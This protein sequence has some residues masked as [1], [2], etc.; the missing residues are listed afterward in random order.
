MSNPYSKENNKRLLEQAKQHLAQC[1]HNSSH[2]SSSSTAGQQQ[3]LS[4]TT[5]NKNKQNRSINDILM[6]PKNMNRSQ[7]KSKKNTKSNPIK[8]PTR[9]ARGK[10]AATGR[11]AIRDGRRQKHASTSSQPKSINGAK[12][13]FQPASLYLYGEMKK[14]IDSSVSFDSTGKHQLNGRWPPEFSS[15]VTIDPTIDPYN[16]LE[17]DYVEDVKQKYPKRELFACRPVL[18]WAPELRWKELYPDERPCCPYHPGETACVRHN[19][20]SGYY[21]KVYDAQGITALTGRE[22]ICTKLEGEK[23]NNNNN[24]NNNSKAK[25]TFYSYDAGVI[26]QAPLY[27]QS[28]WQQ[29][30][31]RLTEKSGLSFKLLEEARSE[32][33]RGHSASGLVKTIEERYK[34][35]HRR[36]SQKWIG[37]SEPVIREKEELFFD[38]EDPKSQLQVPSLS[39]LLSSV[40]DDIEAKIPYYRHKMTMNGGLF[41]SA[42][43]FIKIGKV[44]LIDNE[45]GFVGLYSVMNEFQQILLWRLVEGTTL[46]EVESALRGLNRRYRIHNFRGPLLLTTD[47]C[48]QERSFFEG[49]NNREKKP[50][51]D[52]FSPNVVHTMDVEDTEVT[53]MAAVATTTT[54]AP[55]A[56]TTKMMKVLAL[57]KEPRCPESKPLAEN[58]AAQLIGKCQEKDW[59]VISLDTEWKLGTKTGPDV[60]QIATPDLDTYIFKKPFPN[61]LITLIESPKIKKVASMIHSDRSKLGEIGVT[62]GGE[63]N[64]QAVAKER[65][66]I[67][68]ATVGLAFIFNKAF[69]KEGVTFDKD[70]VTRISDWSNRKLSSEQKKYAALD[71]L[72]QMLSY[73]KLQAIPFVDPQLPAPK[74]AEVKAGD[75]LLLYTSNMSQIVAEGE[76]KEPWK[77]MVYHTSNTIGVFQVDGETGIRRPSAKV[78]ERGKKDGPTL[79]EL[80]LKST[81]NVFDVRWEMKYTRVASN[82]ATPFAI[83]VPTEE[84]EAPMEDQTEMDDNDEGDSSEAPIPDDMLRECQQATEDDDE[85]DTVDTSTHFSSADK[86][87]LLKSGRIKNDIEHI[88]IRFSKVLSKKHGI[89]A[90]FMARL[91]DVFF[92]PNLEDIAFVK[93]ALKEAGLSDDEI[94][95]LPWV[96]FKRRIRRRVPCPRE[97]E[98]SFNKL[99]N[100]MANVKDAKTNLPFFNGKAWNL[101]KSTLKH[102]RK[103]CLSD[104]PEVAYYVKVDEDS[105]GIPIF[106]CLRGTNA[107]EGFHQK[108]RQILR[109]YNISP[110]YAIALLY[111]FI[112]RWNHDRDIQLLGLSTEYKHFYDGWDL[113]AE[114]EAVGSWDR[115]SSP[116]HPSFECTK[117]FQSTGEDFGIVKEADESVE[118]AA[119]NVANSIVDGTWEEIVVA[120]NSEEQDSSPLANQDL[121]ASASWVANLLGRQR[122][123]KPVHTKAEKDFF[124]EHY[125]RFQGSASKDQETTEADN[126]TSIKWG[127]FARFWNATLEQEDKDDEARSDMTYKNAFSLMEY[128]KIMKREGNAAATALPIFEENKAM[129]RDLRGENRKTSVSQEKTPVTLTQKTPE[130]YQKRSELQLEDPFVSL[131]TAASRAAA[132]STFDTEE[133]ANLPQVRTPTRQSQLQPASAN[134]PQSLPGTLQPVTITRFVGKTPVDPKIYQASL[135]QR[136][137]RKQRTKNSCPRR[138]RTCGRD[139]DDLRWREWHPCDRS[140]PGKYVKCITPEKERKEGFPFTGDR[141]PPRKKSHKLS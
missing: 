37:Y 131:S 1:K 93:G 58:E 56:P 98:K 54:T 18:F 63:L 11:E 34:Q 121:T 23:G 2:K 73:L 91:A 135:P 86:E 3:L 132:P 19:G 111:E 139:A 117:H 16:F 72:A 104:V 66:L 118:E 88:F 8:D 89:F 43:H 24:N 40:I 12:G 51:F 55:A 47:R 26:S 97:L 50:I 141:M 127:E 84:K 15:V 70:K 103:G 130:T 53:T 100:L 69:E 107:L 102:I 20:F 49:E 87:D 80:A 82:E 114:V 133:T 124:R 7:K 106:K 61:S 46:D 48:C 14:K 13:H 128:Y 101:Y 109:G 90:L 32:L 68:R 96:F 29:W 115:L 129:R 64:L 125:I 44:I 35:C 85:N 60:I 110:R 83:E 81:G 4:T 22:Y 137:K 25:Y 108:L 122:G 74:M 9:A 105:Y 136:R 31:F 21:R 138:C 92:V 119:D 62:L 75:R 39:F 33:T 77:S 38:F 123:A 78:L 126:Y 36:Q 116:P 67:E 57:K 45:K 95:A 27:V 42:D 113:E 65:G 41:L 134:H 120:N 6:A 112:H 10:V 79:H 76:F 28:V 17:L 52:S 94:D 5:N 30:G 71:V 99:V 140:Q 59:D